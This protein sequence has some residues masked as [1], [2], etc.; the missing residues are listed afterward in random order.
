MKVYYK[1]QKIYSQNKLKELELLDLTFSLY[2]QKDKKKTIKKKQR[3]HNTHIMATFEQFL[4]RNLE[5]T[6]FYQHL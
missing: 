5:L 2:K 4:G 6:L 1:L 3:K